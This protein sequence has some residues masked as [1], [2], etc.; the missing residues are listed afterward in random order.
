VAAPSEHHRHPVPIC[1]LNRC[2]VSTGTTRLHDG[3]HARSCGG[4]DPFCKRKVRVRSHHGAARA[5]TCALKC[6]INRNAAI[7][8]RRSNAERGGVSRND[9]CIRANVSHDA[10]CKECVG[11]LFQRRSALRDHAE[12]A[13]FN[14]PMVCGLHQERIAES[15]ELRGLRVFWFVQQHTKVWTSGECG[16]GTLVC[17]AWGDYRLITPARNLYSYCTVDRHVQRNDCS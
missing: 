10:P 17:H 5:I 2:S 4:G 13:A 16:G 12:F 14:G 15:N 6:N 11:E 3:G 7:H 8:L 9:N 1:D